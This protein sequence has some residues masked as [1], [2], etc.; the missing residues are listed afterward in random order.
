[1][2]IFLQIKGRFVKFRLRSSYVFVGSILP[3]RWY[4]KLRLTRFL[5]AVLSLYLQ[6]QSRI[7]GFFYTKNQF[8]KHNF[9]TL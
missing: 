7:V 2:F 3:N 8:D 1:M 4:I 9:A 5:S 6:S